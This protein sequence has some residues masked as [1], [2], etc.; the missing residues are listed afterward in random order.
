MLGWVSKG[1][2]GAVD[3]WCTVNNGFGWVHI[4]VCICLM[5]SSFS[6]SH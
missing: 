4:Q 5:I 2:M 3:G 6:F 1:K